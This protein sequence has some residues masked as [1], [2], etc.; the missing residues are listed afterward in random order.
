MRTDLLRVDDALSAIAK[1]EQYAGRGRET[2]FANELI[3]VWCFYHLAIIGE[4]LRAVPVIP[5]S[6]ATSG[7]PR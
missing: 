2:F 4:A 6:G 5:K 7:R 3:Q 1:I